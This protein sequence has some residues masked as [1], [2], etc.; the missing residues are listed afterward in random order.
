MTDKQ[1]VKR[2]NQKD[3]KEEIGQITTEI[4]IF[5]ASG[6]KADESF[7]K[8]GELLVKTK[9]DK[10]LPD[11]YFTGLKKVAA[12]T[13]GR[14]SGLRNINKVVAIAQ[15]EAIQKNKDKLPKSWTTLSLL[16]SA[17]NLEELIKAGTLKSTSSRSEVAKLT[18]KSKSVVPQ[19]VY[20]ELAGDTKTFTDVQLEAL[21]K[22]LNGSE[23]VVKA[24]KVETDKKE[25]PT[26]KTKTKK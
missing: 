13:L 7:L 3:Y 8:V 11:K 4:E 20:V 23:W 12:K 18:K 19:W 15:C 6:D 17:E 21:K 5:K 14:E 24:K 26:K 2:F 10:N 22:L 16:T 9:N 25:V 1:A